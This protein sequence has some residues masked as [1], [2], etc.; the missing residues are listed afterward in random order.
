M[1]EKWMRDTGLVL[2][3]LCLI[4][5]Y[6][7][8]K[9]LLI[10]SGILIA[11]ALLVPRALYPLA[12]LWLK[13]V[14]VLGAIVPKIFFSLVFFLIVTPVGYTRRLVKGDVFLLKKWKNATTAFTG[15]DHRYERHDLET[16]Y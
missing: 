10:V 5:G 9:R 1:N 13:L 12:W 16:P 3:L 7:G 8:D 14:Q 4:L 15:R 2:G 6:S 11:L